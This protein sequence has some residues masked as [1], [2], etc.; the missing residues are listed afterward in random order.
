MPFERC[1]LV[2]GEMLGV[3]GLIIPGDVFTFIPYF[4]FQMQYA[5]TGG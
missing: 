3:A 4:S 1:N 5:V 2:T